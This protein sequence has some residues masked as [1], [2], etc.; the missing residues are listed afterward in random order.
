LLHQA[1]VIRRRGAGRS[2]LVIVV[3]SPAA[4]QCDDVRKEDFVG[5]MFKLP[6]CGASRSVPGPQ[7]RFWK[8]IFQKFEDL[9]GVEDLHIVVHEHRDLA[10]WVDAQDFRVLGVIAGAQAVRDHDEFEGHALLQRSDLRLR[11]EHA[12]WTGVK[13]HRSA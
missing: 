1:I 7:W 3:G 2:G 5:A 13:L 12:H 6:R 11:A 9:R 4:H 8:T 10:F